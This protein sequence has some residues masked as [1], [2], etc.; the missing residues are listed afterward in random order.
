M[1]E[2]TDVVS[3]EDLGI[4]RFTVNGN[5]NSA[6]NGTMLALVGN[7]RGTY[8]EDCQDPNNADFVRMVVTADFGRF[9]AR[10]IRPA[11]ETLKAIMDEIARDKPHVHAIM[12]T[13]GMLCCRLVR[14]SQSSI[15]NHSWGTAIDLTLGGHLDAHG[16]GKTQFGLFEIHEI[17]NAHGFYWGAAFPKEDSMH[18]EASDQ[19]IR[20]WARDG[21]LG[22]QPV[23][24]AIGMLNFGDRSPEVF[25][26]QEALNRALG[27]GIDTDGVFGKDTRAAVME[28]QRRNG[29]SVDGVV[30]KPMMAKLGIA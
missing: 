22:D 2:P 21:L 25:S 14:G 10:G 30:S 9:R 26:L 4:D 16:G 12:G 3:F 23:R 5:L 1:R 18:F 27:L 17:F 28:F 15:S 13:A 7:P 8:T 20:R 29:L 19:L 24:V 11:V 6:R